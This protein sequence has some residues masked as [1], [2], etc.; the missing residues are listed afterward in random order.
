MKFK[1]KKSKFSKTKKNKK[2]INVL[3]FFVALII[4]VAVLSVI[5]LWTY[6]QLQNEDKSKPE[7]PPVAEDVF[8]DTEQ[9]KN[10]FITVA[11]GDVLN[12]ILLVRVDPVKNNIFI[13]SVPTSFTVDAGFEEKTLASLF[14]GSGTQR[15]ADEFTSAT[16]IAVNNWISLTMDNIKDVLRYYA[17]SIEFDLTQNLD[18]RGE[19]IN[20]KLSAGR[21]NL[22]SAQV[23]DVI[24][25]P[26]NA[27]QNGAQDHFSAVEN[28]AAAFVNQMHTP[29]RA[30]KL[31][32]DFG[33]LTDI[34]S[35]NM[36]IANFYEAKEGLEWLAKNNKG[37]ISVTLPL[38]G[39]Y[40]G[41]DDERFYLSDTSKK[42]LENTYK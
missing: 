36:S 29:S 24:R 21:Q 34:F 23:I 22:S 42:A 40:V 1:R 13:S 11:D 39:E 33:A 18:Y 10:L 25:Y 30:E 7:E 28:L 2:I 31:E 16:D 41:N 12:S 38:D 26:A 32:A 20:I 9:C 3:T 35:S 37:E 27:W 14:S 6:I 8:T 19:G 5:A 4:F 15:L 17:K